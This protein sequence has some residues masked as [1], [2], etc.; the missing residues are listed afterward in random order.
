[1]SAPGAADMGAMSQASFARVPLFSPPVMRPPVPPAA[2]ATSDPTYLVQV[3]LPSGYAIRYR[4]STMEE[5]ERR[6]RVAAA[7]I[8]AGRIARGA[9][10]T[11]SRR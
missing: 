9:T 8:R 10:V 2:P 11:L 6:A 1:M 4:E 3:E 7:G 5:A